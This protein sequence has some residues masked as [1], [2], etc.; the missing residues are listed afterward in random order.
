MLEESQLGTRYTTA[1][2]NMAYETARIL[3]RIYIRI[4]ILE[5]VLCGTVGTLNKPSSENGGSNKSPWG[6]I[7]ACEG[8]GLLWAG[9]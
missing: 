9:E 6:N 5:S 2:A 4:Y 3:P 8:S 1:P 7:T